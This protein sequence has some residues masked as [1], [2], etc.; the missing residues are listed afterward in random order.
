[1]TIKSLPERRASLVTLRR[2]ELEP[3]H[4][5][6]RLRS[7]EPGRLILPLGSP[8]EAVSLRLVVWTVYLADAY[9][10]LKTPQRRRARLRYRDDERSGTPYVRETSFAIKEPRRP[11]QFFA[12]LRAQFHSDE[13]GMT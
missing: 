13:Y 5:Q 1:M 10:L 2:S 3:E 11:R 6:Y 8:R 7:L 12:I 4:R 9:A